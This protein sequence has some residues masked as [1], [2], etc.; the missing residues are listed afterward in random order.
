MRNLKLIVAAGVVIGVAA[1]ACAALIAGPE[2]TSAVGTVVL[3]I[4]LVG[5][6]FV[7]VQSLSQLRT[8]SRSLQARLSEHSPTGQPLTALQADITAL[9]AEVDGVS[10]TIE[11]LRR[12]YLRNAA[13][14]RSMLVNLDEARSETSDVEQL[15]LAQVRHAL[16][17]S[18]GVLGRQ[19]NQ[20]SARIHALESSTA[21]AVQGT[22][23]EMAELR[24]ALDSLAAG[25]T[26]L[27]VRANILIGLV[28]MSTSTP[29]LGAHK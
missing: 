4:A 24:T 27:S 21:T 12:T 2:V 13:D 9:R 1:V 6:A 8:A 19:Q 22:A 17:Q 7:L 10:A 16:L 23:A 3:L 20:L 26:E 11:S 28:R 5:V 15:T 14:T 18:M 29:E 25:T